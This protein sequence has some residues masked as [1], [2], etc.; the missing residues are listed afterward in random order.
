MKKSLFALLLLTAFAAAQVKLEGPPEPKLTDAKLQTL[1]ASSGFAATVDNLVQ[2]HQQ[3]AWIGYAIPTQD[4][5][6]LICCFDNLHTRTGCCA[7]CRL[8]G[9][10]NGSFNSDGGTCVN[11][12]PP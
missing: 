3:P 5:R 11:N 1:S 10:N 4:K 8:E 6:R 9:H 7:G 12:E 2:Q